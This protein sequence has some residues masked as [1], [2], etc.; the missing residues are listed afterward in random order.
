MISVNELRNGVIYEEAGNL[1]QVLNFEHIKMG[2]GSAN[3]KVKIK[4]LRKGSTVE[5]S[6]INK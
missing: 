6:Y 3:I 4:N 1:L 2:R 5:K